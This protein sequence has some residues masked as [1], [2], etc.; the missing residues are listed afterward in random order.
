[1]L[2]IV[3]A[4]SANFVFAVSNVF[5]KRTEKDTSPTMINLFRTSVGIV[6]FLIIALITNTLPIV[7][8]LPLDLI[9]LLILSSVLGQVMGDTAYFFSQQYL[10]PAKALAVSLTYPFFT[11]LI[12]IFFLNGDFNPWV[13]VAAVIISAGVLLIAYSQK[14]KKNEDYSVNKKVRKGIF[15]GILFAFI[16]SISWA[17][18]ITFT[19]ISMT[20]ID[21]LF[22]TGG[23]TSIVGTMVRFP[24]AV[25]LL[26]SINFSIFGAYKRT[27]NTSTYQSDKIS[28][29]YQIRGRSKSSWLWLILGALV[30]TSLGVYLYTEAAYI[31]GAVTMALM[32]TTGPV[33]SILLDWIVNKEKI[34]LW[35]FIG[36]LLTL[37][38]VVLIVLI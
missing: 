20:K 38:G 9:G 34:S 13:L 26:T 2:G 25:L 28:S 31:A 4:I 37:S 1:M 21:V 10:G 12:D 18:G 24:M 29:H 32:T 15:L 36:I 33:F 5:F 8:Q 22:S 16:A 27:E 11:I 19:D 23:L 17:T 7:F 3:F 35:G 30:G 6:T 14:I